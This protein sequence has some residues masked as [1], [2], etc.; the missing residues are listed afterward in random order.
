VALR[1]SVNSG[2]HECGLRELDDS[3]DVST[4]MIYT[5]TLERANVC[6]I[7]LGRLRRPEQNGSLL[8]SPALRNFY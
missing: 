5:H 8:R 6:L 1:E 7:T 3:S 4:T 2:I